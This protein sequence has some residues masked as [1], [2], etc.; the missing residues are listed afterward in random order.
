MSFEGHGREPPR[1]PELNFSLKSESDFG[2]EVYDWSNN[3]IQ[4]QLPT[5][6]LLIATEDDA[7]NACYSYMNDVCRSYCT[8]LGY[9]DFG[10]FGDG[11][12][13]AL[14][15]CAQGQTAALIA[16]KNAAEVLNPRVVLFVGTCASTKPEKAKLGDVLISW[17]LATLGDKIILAD[18]TLA[19]CGVKV[20]SVPAVPSWGLSWRE[21]LGACSAY[22]V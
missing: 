10:Q 13:V 5:D 11:V 4:S 19:Y 12:L 18:S 3:V 20:G 14:M 8:E 9:V 2:G 17:K 22:R 16:V 6:V 15:K 21:R 1:P 7:F